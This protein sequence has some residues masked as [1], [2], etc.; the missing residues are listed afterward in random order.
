[1]NESISGGQNLSCGSFQVYFDGASFKGVGDVA[2]VTRG[3]CPAQI[4]DRAHPRAGHV[5]LQGHS[6]SL[7]QLSALP[8]APPGSYQGFCIFEKPQ[9]HTA[10]PEFVKFGPIFN[11]GHARL[12]LSCWPQWPDLQ[13]KHLV[14]LVQVWAM[15][16]PFR[17]PCLNTVS[18]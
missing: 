15:D 11:T 10:G 2:R 12:R 9:A 18:L 13:N 8:P 1:M 4:R 16:I 7:V 5:V 3:G 17:Y 6:L 14:P